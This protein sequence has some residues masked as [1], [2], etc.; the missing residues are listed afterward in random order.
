MHLAKLLNPTTWDQDNK[1]LSIQLYVPEILHADIDYLKTRLEFTLKVTKYTEKSY[2][3][4][5]GGEIKPDKCKHIWHGDTHILSI[6]LQKIDNDTKFWETS[7]RGEYTIKGSHWDDIGRLGDELE[8]VAPNNGFNDW[9]MRQ[10]LKDS[11]DE[12][13]RAVMKSFTESNGTVISTDWK[14]VG[15]RKVLKPETT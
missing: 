11:S 4:N 7:I 13:K 1:T 5:L 15:N 8:D 6:T 10:V 2:I 3:V 12:Q 9:M 14:D